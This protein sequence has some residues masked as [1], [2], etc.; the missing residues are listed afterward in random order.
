[1][2]QCRRI[3]E[4]YSDKTYLCV[5]FYAGSQVSWPFRGNLL[6]VYAL[7]HDSTLEKIFLS[8]VFFKKWNGNQK[9]KKN[10][11]TTMRKRS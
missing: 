9:P 1:M 3:I 10:L 7:Q 11:T 6:V 2:S 4:L 5:R 8:K